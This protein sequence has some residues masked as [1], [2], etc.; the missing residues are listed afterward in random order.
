M[1]IRKRYIF[2]GKDSFMI[3]RQLMHYKQFISYVL[4]ITFRET[5]NLHASGVD[6][7]MVIKKNLGGSIKDC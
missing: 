1:N 2:P 4:C 7:E 5:E 6:I 3:I